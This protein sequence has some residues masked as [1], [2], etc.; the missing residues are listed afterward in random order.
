MKTPDN[1]NFWRSYFTQT[2]SHQR[3]GQWL[4]TEDK[5]AMLE[6]LMQWDDRISEETK[7]ADVVCE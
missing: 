6:E 1:A 3:W 7:T 2:E 5:L 4:S